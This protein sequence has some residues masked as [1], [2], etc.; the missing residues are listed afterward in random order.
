MNKKLN[1]NISKILANLPKKIIHHKNADYLTN[2]VL[3]EICKDECLN[4]NTCAYFIYN[5]D[6]H[7]CK[8]IAGI[9]K[10][11]LGK[12]PI[13]DLWENNGTEKQ[14]I[15]E[16]EFNK[17]IKSMQFCTISAEKNIDKIILEI[18]KSITASIENSFT[19]SLPNNNFGIMIFSYEKVDVMSEETEEN[20][21]KISLDEDIENAASLLAFCPIY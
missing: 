21:N 9:K 15:V 3:Y 18:K 11:E 6:F 16:S 2:F 13:D 19:W 10:S 7:L 12:S 8:G 4:F 14:N 5:P 17:T 20:K 1:E